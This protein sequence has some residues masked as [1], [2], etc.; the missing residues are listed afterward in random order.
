MSRSVTF[1][2]L[3]LGIFKGT[4]GV[5]DAVDGVWVFGGFRGAGLGLLVVVWIECVQGVW[6]E[7]ERQRR[8]IDTWQGGEVSMSRQL[9]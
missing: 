7:N 5:F 4:G 6:E 8:A 2:G 3:P 9:C 1:P